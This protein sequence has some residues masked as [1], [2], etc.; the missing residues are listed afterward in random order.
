[1]P[2]TRSNPG[3]SHLGQQYQHTVCLAAWQVGVLQVLQQI[4]RAL[5]IVPVQEQTRQLDLQ[6]EVVDVDAVQVAGLHVVQLVNG[7]HDQQ[8]GATQIATLNGHVGQD[9]RHVHDLRRVK[10]E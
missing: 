9:L 8:L 3:A 4:N 7:T 6:M 10:A 5:K 2:S 1:M